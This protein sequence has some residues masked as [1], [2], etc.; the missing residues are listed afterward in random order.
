[1]S[2]SSENAAFSGVLDTAGKRMHDPPQEMKRRLL[3]ILLASAT[4]LVAT[5]T[6]PRVATVK[7]DDILRKLDSTAKANEEFKA[8]REAITKDSRK[9]AMDEVMADL[10]IRRSKL[11]DKTVQSDQE[12][13]KKLIR[14]YMVRQQEYLSL[15][16]DFQ[17]FTAEKQ[18]ALNAELVA[19]I[20]QRLT[21]IHST[22]EKIAKD[23]G[24]DWLFDSSGI[25]NTGVPVMLYA[26]TP[27]DLTERVLTA[28]QPPKAPEPA[29]ASAPAPD[30]RVT[31]PKQR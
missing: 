10:E 31:K 1:L 18:Q 8:K 11:A 23:E 28:L 26:K 6:P 19:G 5:A 27:N 16:Q 25:S 24:Y 2:K 20:R 15:Q 14:E 3:G 4:C 13:H 21:L 22:A 9:A 7:V 12:T 17:N 29:P 30:T